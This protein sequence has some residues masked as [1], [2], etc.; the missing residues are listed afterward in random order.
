MRLVF[1]HGVQRLWVEL[2]DGSVWKNAETYGDDINEEN[3]LAT[4]TEFIR[5]VAFSK[6]RLPADVQTFEVPHY[7]YILLL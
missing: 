3:T 2:V 4:T 1:L 6:T 7:Y 5:L